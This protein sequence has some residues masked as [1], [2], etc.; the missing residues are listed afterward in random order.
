[1]R[2]PIYSVQGSCSSAF[3]TVMLTIW[4]TDKIFTVTSPSNMQN[5]RLYVA[6]PWERRIFQRDHC[7]AHEQPLAS[8]WWCLLEYQNLDALSEV[9]FVD[10]GAKIIRQYYRD[11]LLQKLLPAI[12]R[13][14]RNHVHFPTRQWLS[15]SCTGHYLATVSQYSKTSLL[16]TCGHLTHWTSTRLTIPSGQSCSSICI[17]P[18]S[19]TSTSCDSVLS[20]CGVDWNSALWMTPLISGNVVWEPLS[21]PK[22]DILNITQAYKLLVRN[23]CQ[24]FNACILMLLC[25]HFSAHVNKR[26]FSFCTVVCL[27][28]HSEVRHFDTLMCEIHY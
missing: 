28:M 15:A 22:A 26:V 7:Y 23:L 2:L 13:V 14:S 21:L 12:Q 20:P 25:K 8:H 5:D 18:E 6:I 11:V 19:M 27:H 10:P 9:I 24:Y 1:M 16:Q 3:V 17:R 4:F